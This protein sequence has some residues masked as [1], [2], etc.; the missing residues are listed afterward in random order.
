MV[1][2][3]AAP[4][5]Y[6]EDYAHA[7]VVEA[8]ERLVF[9]AGACPIDARGDLVGAADIPAQTRQVLANL[10]EQLA[11]AGSSLE[12]VISSTVY[13]VADRPQDLALAW[14]VVNA[15][16]LRTG[17]HTSTLLGVSCLGWEGQLVEVTAVA[18]VD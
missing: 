8:G 18:A 7:A 15:S 17:P 12:K 3:L 10:A 6:P 14:D 13:V 2:R 4:G 5:L 16:G 1:R 11:A 9:T